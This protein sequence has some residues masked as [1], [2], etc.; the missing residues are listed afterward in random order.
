MANWYKIFIANKIYCN[1]ACYLVQMRCPN[2][3]LA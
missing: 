1:R 2:E 3:L